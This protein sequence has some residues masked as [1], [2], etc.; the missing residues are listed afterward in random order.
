[1]GLMDAPEYTPRPSVLAN[2]RKFWLS[3]ALWQQLVLVLG[4]A[5]IT[6]MIGYGCGRAIDCK[7]G[8]QDGQCGLGTGMGLL[9]GFVAACG[10][11]FFGTVGTVLN[12][13]SE[14]QKL[15]GRNAIDVWKILGVVLGLILI[16]EGVPGLIS[17][18]AYWSAGNASNVIFSAIEVVGGCGLIF[19]AFFKVKV[20]GKA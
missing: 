10:V 5:V 7:P 20:A 15:A 2:L 6:Q 16:Y 14:K 1:M 19:R 8:E 13:V 18:Q 11:L 4:L 9:A 17:Y 12:K 3:R